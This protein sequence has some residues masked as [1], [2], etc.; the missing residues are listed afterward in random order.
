MLAVIKAYPELPD[1]ERLVYRVGRRGG[2]FRSTRDLDR[3]PATCRK[4]R[5]MIAAVQLKEG[6]EAVERLITEM[7]DQYI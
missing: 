6:P 7:V 5:E 1:T 3:D 2:A 4:I